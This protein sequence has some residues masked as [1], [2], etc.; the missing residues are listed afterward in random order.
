MISL[1]CNY[2]HVYG[3]ENLQWTWYVSSVADQH[4]QYVQFGDIIQWWHLK[5]G[6]VTRQTHELYVSRICT[7]RP[8]F[9]RNFVKRRGS[10]QR[11]QTRDLCLRFHWGQFQSRCVRSCLGVLAAIERGAPKRHWSMPK[12]IYERRLFQRSTCMALSE[13]GTYQGLWT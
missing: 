1:A 6:C 5:V 12:S 8:R 13:I 3:G 7:K 9:N 10:I 11:R 2:W 4:E